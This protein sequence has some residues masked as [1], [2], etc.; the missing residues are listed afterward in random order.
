MAWNSRFIPQVTNV[1]FWSKPSTNDAPIA[2]FLSK[3]GIGVGVCVGVGVRVL[4][5]VNV[6]VGLLSVM[7]N[8]RVTSAA[9]PYVTP[10]L[11]PAAADALTVHLPN[12]ITLILP[13]TIVQTN[14]VVVVY[15]TG[16]PD[17]A[18]AAGVIS[19]PS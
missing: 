5:G 9:A 6:S 4:V 18:V 1:S 8:S 13:P 16:C 10:P 11:V 15:V 3:N 7:K 17:N 2:P 12:P 19:S 14:G